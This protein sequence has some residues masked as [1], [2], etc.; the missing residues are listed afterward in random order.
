MALHQK[1]NAYSAQLDNAESIG[2]NQ[3]LVTSLI[4]H[5][6]EGK[7]VKGTVYYRISAICM[8]NNDTFI[9]MKVK[10][11]DDTK[12]QKMDDENVEV[13]EPIVASGTT[14]KP[15]EQF[16]ATTYDRACGN[17]GQGTMVKLAVTT[18]WYIDHFTFQ[19]SKVIIDDKNCDV[20]TRTAYDTN[21]VNT[22]LACIP[23]K[24]N[25]SPDDFAVG[26][27]EK[28]ITRSFITPL[29]SG[30]GN[31]LFSNVEIQLDPRDEYRFY[32]SK[33]DD[34][35]KYI[36]VNFDTG[37][38]KPYNMMKVVYT[39]NNEDETKILMTY[40]Y[41]PECWGCFGITNLEQ[42]KLVAG[43][44][45]FYAVDWLVYGYSQH[46]KIMS[47]MANMDSNDDSN[48]ES[49]DEDASTSFM[50][51]TGFIT[52]MGIDI[53][54]TVRGCGIPLSFNYIVNNYGPES[55]YEND[56]AI[57][58]GFNGPWNVLLKRN[59]QFVV[60]MTD[61]SSDE[62][63]IFIKGYEKLDGKHNI[64]FYGIY[65][66]KSDAPYEIQA[67]DDASREAKLV[68]SGVKPTV[69]FA[70]NTK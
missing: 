68:E 15:G 55:D 60:N 47:I 8:S 34:P 26:T 12:K 32:T 35:V 51:S 7:S 54:N 38:D 11:D 57:M 70:V 25:F 1:R 30:T 48:D 22:S 23:T 5:V 69:V 44:M 29:S 50:Y 14:I 49:D 4:K 37:G 19:A 53:G 52:K 6:T 41:M 36:G 13:D 24:D 65:D 62:V 59:K 10:K 2:A 3:T 31:K 21:V 40:A 39:L 9:K 43:R 28:Y 42:W 58:N 46:S 45:I 56:H 16:M 20:L 18:D 17:V 27:D 67:E 33:R 64:K 63:S 66:V 61:L